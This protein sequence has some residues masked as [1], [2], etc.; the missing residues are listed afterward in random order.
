MIIV[1]KGSSYLEFTDKFIGVS[2]GCENCRHGCKRAGLT[3]VRNQEQCSNPFLNRW[4]NDY[5]LFVT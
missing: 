1:N 4:V 3:E 2:Y 5:V